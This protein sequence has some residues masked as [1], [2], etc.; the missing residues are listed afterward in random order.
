V[1][2][3]RHFPPA[4]LADP[5]GLLMIGGRLSPDWLLDAYGHGIFPWPIHDSLLAWW[6]P[7]PRA[8]LEFEHLHVSRRLARTLRRRVFEITCNRDFAGVI[9]GCAT[10]QD[11]R[12]HTWLTGDM[13]TAYLRLHRLGYAHSVEAWQQ[14][15]LAGGVYGVALGAAFFAESMFYRV[16]DASKVALVH[17]VDHLQRRGFQLLD[18]QQLTPHT[19]RLGGSEIPRAVFLRR[20]RAALRVPASFGTRV[21]SRWLCGDAGRGESSPQNV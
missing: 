5:D 15:Q 10:A 20:L 16:A 3:P 21:E 17:L 2:A 1:E 9:G 4:E 12:D 8:V 19:E 11:R 14:G 6:S 7:D 13:C 18:I